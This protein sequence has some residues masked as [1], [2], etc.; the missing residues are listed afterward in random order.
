[1]VEIKIPSRVKDIA[2]HNYSAALTEQGDLV[3]WGSGS[4]GN[5]A[6]P[7]RVS[8]IPCEVQSFSLS[9]SH[10]GAVDSDGMIWVWGSNEKGELGLGDYTRR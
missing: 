5:F 6:S 1:M 10:V 7:V 3:L 2:C 9:D 4:F 8:G